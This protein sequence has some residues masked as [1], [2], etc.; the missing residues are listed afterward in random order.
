MVSPK[1]K[2]KIANPVAASAAV[3]PHA[4]ALR[5]AAAPNAS[6]KKM[7][8]SGIP[9]AVP[10]DG[11]DPANTPDRCAA[12]AT[13]SVNA[14]KAISDAILRRSVLMADKLRT[15]RSEQNIT[16]GE[17]GLTPRRYVVSPLRGTKGV[18][19]GATLGGAMSLAQAPGR[20]VVAR[21]RSERLIDTALAVGAF[22]GSLLL[23]AH[24]TGATFT[25][26]AK[27]VAGVVL[28]ACSSLPIL[29]WRRAPLAV[30]VGTTVASAT[31]M[32]I[33]SAGGPPIG[34]TI[35]LYLL[36]TS[37]DEAHPWTRRLTA[38]VAVLFT[39]H[40]V[41][42]AIGQGTVPG[43]ELA[44]GALVWAVAWFAGDRTRLR[45]AEIAELQRR[46]LLAEQAAARERQLAA[47][48]ERA[49]IARDLHDSAGHA[50]NVIAVH[51]GAARLLHE[52]DP[53]RS[54]AAI[55]TI[56]RVARQTV[57]EI[58]QI[59][60]SLR[61]GHD[62]PVETPPG[63]AALDALVATHRAT[64]LEIAVSREG[65]ARPLAAPLDQA[66]FR[67][68]QEALTNAARHGTGSAEVELLF[69]ERAVELAVINPVN[70]ATADRANGGGH[71]LVG[72]RE[73][74]GMLGG[75]VLAER[76]GDTFAV[77]AR[78]PYGAGAK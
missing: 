27:G 49:R 12:E 40:F 64:G 66:A 35:A 71:G 32:A 54:R 57:G 14:A 24:G 59:V 42:Y 17:I 63:L 22:T 72:M 41:G 38:T 62:P 78:L 48:E 15:P 67:I 2:P 39:L 10:L 3:P 19:I 26:G 51:A 55:E 33:G 56:E 4:G 20:S 31:A 7:I 69:G 13:A 45:R 9:A 18:R 5:S 70:G 76:A 43:T 37:R 28:A 23:I 16:S 65:D 29:F 25:G 34:P 6:T 47:A 30:F 68:L 75:S 46:A 53:A 50:I 44:I 52:R 73:R 61:I 11:F 8:A 21:R 36:A 77:R 1:T 58:D 74:A 60:R